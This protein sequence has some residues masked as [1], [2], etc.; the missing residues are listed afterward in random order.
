[1]FP[2]CAGIRVLRPWRKA[3][4]LKRRSRFYFV[5]RLCANSAGIRV[6][7]PWRKATKLK[8]LSR[9]YFVKRLCANS[10]GIRVLRPWR[11]ATNLLITIEG[12]DAGAT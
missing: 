3:T 6:L 5:K 12:D 9:F 7:R 2:A 10:A 8:R 1:M 4:K 11:K